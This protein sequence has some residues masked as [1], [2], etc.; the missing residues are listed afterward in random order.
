MNTNALLAVATE[1]RRQADAI[2]KLVRENNAATDRHRT[3]ALDIVRR[4]CDDGEPEEAAIA[5]AAE[6][7]GSSPRDIQWA[8][9]WTE[10]TERREWRRTLPYRI[11]DL[12]TAGIKDAEIARIIGI[13]RGQVARIRRRMKDRNASGGTKNQKG[14]QG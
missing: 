9:R 14:Q 4:L 2:E 5:A 13:P 6:A 12:T 3:T 7:M 10:G 1:L 8:W 11:S